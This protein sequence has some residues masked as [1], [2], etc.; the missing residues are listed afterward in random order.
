MLDGRPLVFGAQALFL[1]FGNAATVSI[2]HPHAGAVKGDLEREC[3]H[4]NG[5]KY[6]AIARSQLHEWRA[7]CI[8]DAERKKQ[9]LCRQ[10]E[11]PVVNCENTAVAPGSPEASGR[12]VRGVAKTPYSND[13]ITFRIGKGYGIPSALRIARGTM[14]SM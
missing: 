6:R 14:A 13:S 8:H 5:L 10:R 1:Q 4:L 12:V 11:K 2:C 7:S 9:N 3:A